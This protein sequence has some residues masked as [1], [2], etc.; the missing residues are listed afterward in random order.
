MRVILLHG[1]AWTLGRV[2]RQDDDAD[3]Y[4]KLLDT[5][6]KPIHR[7]RGQL[8]FAECGAG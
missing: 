4:P 8:I 7:R 1:L 5:L 2:G 3:D 6:T